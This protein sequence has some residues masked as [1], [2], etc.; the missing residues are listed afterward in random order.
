M[1][2]VI[3]VY[4]AV[5]LGF[6]G[7]TVVAQSSAEANPTTES[8]APYI[9]IYQNKSGA[10]TSAAIFDPGDSRNRLL[11]TNLNSGLI[12]VLSPVAENIFSAGPGLLVPLPI[13]MQV[14]FHRTG[15]EQ[16]S[17]LGV[18]KEGLPEE[19]AT[20][21]MCRR[22]EV[23]FKDGE[24]SLAGTLITPSV[25]Q[26][27]AAV[28]FLHGSGAL[29]RYSFGPFPD[30]FVSQG[31][32]VLVYDKRGTVQSKGNL[33]SSSLNDLVQMDERRSAS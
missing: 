4:I 24:I 25:G 15:T 21:V 30:F 9:G 5:A 7:S 19:A 1:K 3:R 14:T 12:R 22:E 6:F 29:N 27:H 33:D 28:V 8:L 18:R 32:A 2:T 16:A 11:F 31:F 26:T 10:F 20:R 23:T 13:E 17:G